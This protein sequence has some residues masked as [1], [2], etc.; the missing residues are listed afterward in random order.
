MKDLLTAL[1][2]GGLGEIGMNGLV[3][4]Y[5]GRRLLIDCGVMFPDTMEA[6]ADLV[7]PDL[8]FFAEHG[9]SFGAMVLTHGHEDHIGAVPFVLKQAP[10]PVYGSPF[11]LGLVE[12]RLKEH[13]LLERTELR[14]LEPSMRHDGPVVPP[15]LPDFGLSM[16]RVTHSI[17]DAASL[18]IHTPK[19]VVLHTGDFKID[20]HPIDNQHFDDNAFRNLG[21]HGVL[22]MLSDSTNAQVPG[23]TRSEKETLANI[24]ERIEHWRGRIFVTQ[25]ASNLHRLLGLEAIAER[26]GRRLCLVG[27][28]LHTYT[29]VARNADM[30]CVDEDNLLDVEQLADTP[31]DEVMVVMTGSQGEFRSALARASRCEHRHI[32]FKKG[33]RLLMSARFIPGNEASIFDLINDLARLGVDVIH[34]LMAPIHTSGHARRDELKTMLELVR[35]HMFVPVH[36]THAFLQAHRGLAEDCGVHDTLLI[37]NG[38]EFAAEPERGLFVVD[39]HPMDT[40]YYDGMHTGDA[41]SLGLNERKK[42]FFNGAICAFVQIPPT[43]R[44]FRPKVTLQARGLYTDNQ[45]LL[46]R[47]ATQVEEELVTLGRDATESEIEAWT[48]RS[49]RRFFRI[50]A[51][52]KPLVMT[53]VYREETP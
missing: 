1:P 40:Y 50:E 43:G 53:A 46:A 22:L 48:Q 52:R 3:L 26:C 6:S 42:L 47:A 17:P 32:A 9:D 15:E 23:R 33:D 11:T 36:G 30:P 34:P 21:D 27:R 2:L 49:V 45:R 16:I 38:K 37:E 28:S 19:G 5:Q 25:F 24:E 12:R 18:V 10:M 35:P 39:E 51:G 4:T 7:L 44:A 41:D 14:I 13:G 31:D 20:P 8:R 29:R